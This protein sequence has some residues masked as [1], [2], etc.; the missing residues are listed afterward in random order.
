MLCRFVTA[1]DISLLANNSNNERGGLQYLQ[2]NMIQTTEWGHPE[3]TSFT[4]K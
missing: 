1:R 3:K 2:G 4:L